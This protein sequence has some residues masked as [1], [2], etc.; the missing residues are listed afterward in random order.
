MP[1]KPD[2]KAFLQP[3][4][5]TIP[6][7]QSVA[8]TA[9]GAMPQ[10]IARNVTSPGGAYGP[11]PGNGSAPGFAYGPLPGNTSAPGYAY[12]PLP[13]NTS[14]P[15]YAY[16]PLPGNTS[17]PGYAY[18]PLP[19]NTSAP[20]YRGL[21]IA[22]G[23]RGLPNTSAP[24]YRQPY[25]PA[26]GNTTAPGLRGG[27]PTRFS[28]SNPN[29]TAP[30]FPAPRRS[31]SYSVPRA[32][33]VGSLPT[34]NLTG[35]YAAEAGKA[36]PKDWVNWRGPHYNSKSDETGLPDT[37]DP[38]GPDLLW[39]NTELRGRSTPIVM[40]GRL[41]TMNRNKPETSEEG[42]R[43]L[44]ADAVTGE[45][46]WENAFNVWLS[47]VPDTR[48]GW[49]SVVGDP[50]TDYVYALG[51]CGYFQCIEGA[52]GK[53]V[54]SV[55]MHEHFGL[56]STYGGRTNYPIIVDDLVIVS[57][58]VIGWGDQAKPAH[59][60]VAFDKKTGDVVWYNGTAPLPD[61]TTY[62]SPALTVVNGEK[63][64]VFGSGDGSVWSFQPR[65]G[66]RLWFYEFARRGLNV[67]PIVANGIVY[68]NQAEENIVPPDFP[69]TMG[70]VVALDPSAKGKT[71]P[72]WRNEEIVAG[73][74]SPLEIDGRIY[75]FDDR[76]K[77]WVYD[78]KTGKEIM[79]KK[80]L[81][82]VMQANAL[83]AD[84]RIYLWTSGGRWYVLTPTEKGFDID[85]KGRFPQ[86]EECI[87][88]PIVSH[89][90]IYLQTTEAMY[91]LEDKTK[92]HGLAEAPAE[93]EETPIEKDMTPAQIQI[94]PAEV[95]MKPSESQAFTVRVFNANGQLLSK[96]SD[97]A[98]FTVEGAGQVDA[99]GVFHPAADSGHT[100]AYV[101][102][103]VGEL[104]STSRIRI[105]PELP[106]K[107][108]FTGKKEP[109]VTWVGARYRH[110]I[111][112]V[113]GN[114]MM[115]KITTIP[116]GTRSR[117]WFGQSDLH[118][119]TIQADVKG[120]ITDGKMPDIGLIAQGYKLDLQGASQI[121]Q[122]RAWDPQLRMARQVDLD[123]K[124]DTW[125]TMKFRAETADGKAILKGKIWP[126]G[127]PEPQEWTVEA[128]DKSPQM[129]GSPGLY[130]NAKDAE[131][132]LDNITV[133]EN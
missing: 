56:L 127:Q 102:A 119:Y 29:T 82:T 52:T 72:I 18:G 106:W 67:A 50:E 79:G 10:G 100:A 49:S 27:L 105:V 66:K 6:Y 28:P 7:H 77:A 81:G 101:T 16:G 123:W 112:N 5:I 61:D 108:D 54:W 115:V 88:S 68:T 2:W 120:S 15:G 62:S 107:F 129:T 30:R 53:T 90:R 46:L 63:Q 32:F 40:N 23:Y 39:R 34:Q 9:P 60:F 12:G 20:G 65:T 121:L 103:K 55:P 57:A 86:G 125:Y 87:S 1:P 130:G 132:F 95:L 33:E 17:A 22:P 93:P 44:C 14:A 3:S 8:V 104:S 89:G 69:P 84:G 131:I 21:P 97:E 85:E 41:Y 110:I 94:V 71:T 19:G 92:E 59:R 116:K 25:G 48:V 117:A 31:G 74:A 11:N 45:I 124:P 109:P 43:V 38:E 118:D 111:R 128:E 64:M 122:I 26:P 75:I 70:G 24:G 114:D 126:K 113:D 83:Y 91:C 4:G 13:G 47:D 80:A 35:A 58:I 51:V 78:A 73:R 42:E 98:T 36:D 37:L 99:D 133:T 96:T 76:A